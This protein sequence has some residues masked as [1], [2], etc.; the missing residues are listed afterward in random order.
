[1]AVTKI[2]DVVIP[3]VYNDYFREQSIYKSAVWRS[4]IITTDPRLITSLNGGAEEF[5]FPFWQTNDVTGAFATPVQEDATLS[6]GSLSAT[7]MT[8]RRQFR[9]KAFGHNDVAAVLA[10]SNPTDQLITMTSEFWAK[11]YQAVLF[12]SLQGVI[13]DNDDN[14]SDDMINDITGDGDPYISSDA[15]IDTMSLFGDQPS[16]MIRGIAMHSI[17]YT[18]LLKDNLIDTTSDNLQNIGWGTYLGKT[19]IVD[20]TLVDDSTYWVVVY[21]DGAFLWGESLDSNGNYVPTEVN[22][23]P[24]ASGGQELYYT[25]R[26]FSIHP[27]GFS[28]EEDSVTNDFPTDTELETASNWDRVVSSVK[29]VGFAVLKC[30]G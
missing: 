26:V 4:G 25:R 14:D 27:Y 17:P 29:N 19:I 30:S 21:K 5:N 23:D 9:E 12:S 24:S 18:R 16:G 7:K 3:E 10:G 20:D 15:V 8:V 28:W 1:M 22:R 2:T 6:A 13:A 11:N